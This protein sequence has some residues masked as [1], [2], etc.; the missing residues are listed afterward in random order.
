[1]HVKAGA[2]AVEVSPITEASAASLYSEPRWSHDGTRIA[3]THW[4]RGGT[5]G[6][7]ILDR[8]GRVLR[9]LGYARSVNG[10][11]AWGPGDSTIYFTSDRSG[12]SAIYRVS[13][14]SGAIVRVAD[15]PTALYESEP[16]PDGTKLATF[17]LGAD[18]YDLSVVDITGRGTPADSTS[19]LPPSRR[20]PLATADAPAMSYSAWSTLLP[21]YWTPTVELGFDD[22][23]RFG[24]ITGA[25]DIVDRHAWQLA[26]NYDAQHKE[27]GLDFNYSFSGFGT[28][29]LG[30][31]ATEVWD[32]PAVP[33]SARKFLYPVGR[34]KRFA[35]VSASFLRRRFKTFASLTVG[36]SYEWRDFRALSGVPFSLFAPA[37]RAS[38]AKAYTY[39]SVFA[40]ASFSNARQPSLALGPENG[41]SASA[42]VRQRW[43]SDAASAT[44]ATSVVGSVT[45]YRG[46]DFGGRIHHLIAARVAAGDQGVTSASEFAAGGGSGGVVRVVPGVTLGE[47]RRTFF[48]RGF[49][50]GSQ[51]GSRAIGANLEYRAPIA[52]PARGLGALPVYFQRISAVLFAD[53]ASAWCPA[54]SRTSP[55]CPR[56]TPQEWMGSVGAE[57]HL[58]ATAQYD[59]TNRL[60]F[61]VAMPVTGT[62]YRANSNPSLYFTIGLPF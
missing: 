29:A 33:D 51:S 11:P 46:F 52:L 39:P 55:I 27:P 6:I 22:A 10:A 34:R 31:G 37:D 16:S 24:L 40:G 20:T 5:S 45:G 2:T 26:A 14:A 56:A 47:G 41:F 7:D 19:V 58:D 44:R 25:R 54:G 32:H 15:S 28:P 3:A 9:S 48:V 8:S 50:G 38:L 35:D 13:V 43:R 12:R 36:G 42:T 30:V 61:G 49:E 17:L 59:A 1:M 57:L 18:G 62:K 23:T 53:G 4:L 21:R 60:R